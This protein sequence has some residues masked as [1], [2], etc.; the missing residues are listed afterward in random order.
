MQKFDFVQ[1]VRAFFIASKYVRAFFITDIFLNTEQY[2]EPNAPTWIKV[3]PGS[4]K[5]LIN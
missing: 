2:Y 5:L 3:D 4:S 1:Y